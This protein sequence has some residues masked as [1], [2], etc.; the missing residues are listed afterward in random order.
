MVSAVGYMSLL[1]GTWVNKHNVRTNQVKKPNY[2]YWDIFRIAK[3]SNP[4]LR[5]ALFSTWTDN[6]TKL[7]GDGLREA[8]GTKLDYYFD[9]LELDRNGFE[10]DS[11][12]D[13]IQK[14]DGLV[15]N[16]ASEYLLRNAPDLS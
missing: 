5:T 1:T 3:M 10:I 6:R 13:R 9:E 2:E 12:S 7:L 4:K 16:E 15:A 11:E 14:I 8:G